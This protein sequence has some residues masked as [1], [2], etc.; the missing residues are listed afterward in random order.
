M[1]KLLYHLN[2][3]H[4]TSNLMPHQLLSESLCYTEVSIILSKNNY[5]RMENAGL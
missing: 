5:K 4:E 3:F 2:A 1:I